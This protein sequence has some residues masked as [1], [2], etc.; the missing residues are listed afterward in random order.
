MGLDNFIF[1]IIVAFALIT[2]Q[3][4]ENGKTSDW[5]IKGNSKGRNR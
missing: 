2:L 5:R 1:L 4:W 3:I